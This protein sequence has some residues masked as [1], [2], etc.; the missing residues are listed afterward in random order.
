[1]VHHGE[2]DAV[3]QAEAARAAMARL[4]AVAG[5]DLKQPLQVAVMSIA[6]AAK[7]GLAPGVAARLHVALEALERLGCELDDLAR[8]SQVGSGLKPRPIIFPLRNVLERVELDWRCYA[9]ATGV[10]VRVRPSRLHVETD[11]VMLSTILRNLLGNAIK[12]TRAGGR[13]LVGCRT[14]REDVIVEVHDSG[15]GIAGDRLAAIFDAFDRGGREGSD[16]GLGL[17]LHIVRQTAEMLRHP[18]AVRSVEERGSTFSVRVPL[19]G[20]IPSGW[21]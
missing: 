19:A 7:D 8:S 20:R 11:P 6:R 13:V 21:A 5:H 1:M 16:D 18:I 17:G 4:M 2:A 14:R 12:Y 15:P 10:D 9:Q 3:A